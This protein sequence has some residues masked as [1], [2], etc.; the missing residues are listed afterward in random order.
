MHD[1]INGPFF[2]STD[3]TD[4]SLLVN[5]SF[6]GIVLSGTQPYLDAYGVSK[7]SADARDAGGVWVNG[8]QYNAEKYYN[9]I[10]NLPGYYSYDATNVRLQEA[11]INYAIDGKIISNRVKR[12]TLGVI[13]T[14]LLMIYN[15]APFDP[16]LSFGLGTYASTELFMTPAMKTYGMSLKVQ[17]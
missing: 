12:I 16:Q 1:C 3:Y 5:G 8:K 10:Q 15:K 4:L 14:N 11:S 6:G 7:A 17:F 9:T 2:N 13:G